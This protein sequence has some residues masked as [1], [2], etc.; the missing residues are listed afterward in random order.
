MAPEQAGGKHVAIGPPADV[1]ALG[2]ILYEMLTG[3]PPFQGATALDTLEQVRSQ[4]PIAPSRLHAKLPRD[5]ETICLKCLEKQPTKRYVTAEELADD[6]NRFLAGEPIRARP[7]RFWTRATKWA[8]RRPAAA[9]LVGTIAAIIAVGFP[10]TTGLWV[11]AEHSRAAAEVERNKADAARLAE[12]A[13][14]ERVETLLYFHDVNL[15]HHEYLSHNLSRATQLLEGCRPDLRH[16]E[17]H[18]LDRLCHSALASLPHKLPVRGIAWSPDGKLLATCTGHW[19]TGQQGEV[20]IWDANSMKELFKLTGHPSSVTGVAFSP[21]G[22]RLASVGMV[23]DKPAYGGAIIWN[24]ETGDEV[25]SIPRGDGLSVAFSPDGKLLAIGRRDGHV[26]LCDSLT[27]DL[28]HDLT[29][30]PTGTFGVAFSPDGKTVASSGHDGTAR[31]WNVAAGDLL[32]TVEIPGSARSVA[33][34]PDG[35]F[36]TVGSYGGVIKVWDLATNREVATRETRAGGGKIAY[37]PDGRQIAVTTQEAGVRIWDAATGTERR[38][39]HG[40]LGAPICVAFSPDGRRLASGGGWDTAAMVWDMTA[41]LVPR[42]FTGHTSYIAD[43]AIRPDGQRLA[44]AGTARTSSP[45]RET[46]KTTRVWDLAQRR[47]IRELIGHS[48]WLTSVAYSPDGLRLVTGSRDRTA[49]IWNADTGQMLF[50]LEG[51]SDT[52][53]SVSFSPDNN[54]V[55]L[56][57]ADRTVSVWNANAGEKTRTLEGHEDRLNSVA[58]GP[59]GRYLASAG[60]DKTVRIWDATGKAIR[61]LRGHTGPVTV[62]AFS[63]DGFHLAS[64][65]DDSL[66]NIWDVSDLPGERESPAPRLVLRG[67]TDTILSLNFSPD[68]KRLA[69]SAWDAATKVWDV[70]TGQETI[71]F[72]K[73][74]SNSSPVLFSPDS[75]RIINARGTEVSI[76]ESERASQLIEAADGDAAQQHAIAWHE[77]ELKTCTRVGN[78]FAAAFHLGRLI[79]AKPDH[80]PYFVQRG[81]AYFELEQWAKAAADYEQATQLDRGNDNLWHRSAYLHLRAG[82]DAGYRALC[83]RFVAA[84]DPGK[85]CRIANALAWTCV[86]GPDAGVAPDEIVRLAERGVAGARAEQPDKVPSYLNTLGAALFRAGRYDEAIQRL[87]DAIDAHGDD[88]TPSDWLFLAMAHHRQG[89]ITDAREWLDVAVEWIEQQAFQKATGGDLDPHFTPDRQIVL[90]VLRREAESMLGSTQ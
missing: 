23:P 80:R 29:G 28:V 61:V 56:A 64:G 71:T 3:V 76:W 4:E 34:S 65:G 77:S 7:I 41:D 58:Y 13:E 5:L 25:L 24:V 10:T 83:P 48:D 72:R 49:K 60:A 43:M 55:A 1:Y 63:R 78:W 62:V 35:R 74:A 51:H 47:M 18:Y 44:L 85:D 82:N 26:W 59:S 39:F 27:G 70:A 8:K 12:Q 57:S 14:R 20:N 90:Q 16:W 81:R 40:H 6:L 52:V 31:I 53:T 67:H 89:H 50:S 30:H 68:G 84:F 17:W 21:D 54:A 42:Q 19:G 38:S 87:N 86:L 45:G 88:G 2:A 11:R 66:V 15:A 69:S 22:S 36:L 37:S 75:K 46:P 73:T 33:Y 9:A 79:A 32:L